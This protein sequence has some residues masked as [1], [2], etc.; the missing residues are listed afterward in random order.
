MRA[1]YTG[2]NE[3]T[4]KFFEVYGR[5][6]VPFDLFIDSHGKE[7][8]TAAAVLRGI[9]EHL[10]SGVPR[11]VRKYD[12]APFEITD[13]FVKVI[14]KYGIDG[15]EVTVKDTVN[16]LNVKD[17]TLIQKAILKEIFANR[18]ITTQELSEKIKINVRNTKNNISKLKA[19]GLLRRVGSDKSG[20]WEVVKSDF[21]E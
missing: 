5:S 11:I 6:A 20:C 4:L 14:F 7:I 16:D 13:N 19:I 21:Y 8:L 17:L 10:G 15:D 9:V 18:F 2:P 12:V 3:E 1:D